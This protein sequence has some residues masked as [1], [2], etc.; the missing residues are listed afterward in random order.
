MTTGATAAP[1]R[2]RPCPTSWRASSSEAA[3]NQPVIGEPDFQET[4]KPKP[5]SMDEAG[6]AY[7]AA[8]LKV[9]DALHR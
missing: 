6:H 7:H 4:T 8:L 9:L 3:G 1:R 5:P 2:P